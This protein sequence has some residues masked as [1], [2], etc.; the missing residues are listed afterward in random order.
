[1]TVADS[2]VNLVAPE[3]TGR[4]ALEAELVGKHLTLANNVSLGTSAGTALDTLVGA[5]LAGCKY[6]F[7]TDGSI[8]VSI[9]TGL[10]NMNVSNTAVVHL[11]HSA[12]GND[13][14]LPRSALDALV[15]AN[16][17]SGKN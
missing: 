8:T 13:T 10:G 17:T 1:M 15:G 12:W 5:N 3:T 4:N 14:R 11:D 9:G 16:F 7:T 2:G 6:G